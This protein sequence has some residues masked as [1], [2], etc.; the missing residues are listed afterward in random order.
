MKRRVMKKMVWVWLSLLAA[1]MGA[2]AAR[3]QAIEH[4]T[5]ANGARVW[6][7][8]SR[9][10]PMVDLNIAF[11]AGSRRD[12]SNQAG[13]AAVT[14]NLMS[15]GV[16]AHL[17]RPALDENQLA[18][19]WADLGA[20]FNDSLLPD[21]ISFNL[22]TLSYPDILPQAVA[23]AAQQLAAP[24]F[25]APLWQRERE[26]LVAA[27]KESRN[28]PGVVAS[29]NFARAVYRDHP[30]GREWDE[31]SLG[32]IQVGDLRAWHGR[33]LHACRAKVT[34][35]G[36]LNRAQADA[37]V[38][39]LLQGLPTGGACAPLP[40][41]PEVAPL[42]SANEQKQ[43][44]DSAQAHVY[45]GQPGF[46]REDPDFFALLVGNHIL[47]GGG[48]T[49]RLSREVREQ[50]GLSY[51]V[52]SYFQPGLHAGAFVVNLQTRPD[53][54]AQALQVARDVVRGFVAAGPSEA[55]LQ[56]AR[57]N[58]INGFAL[59]TDSNRKLLDNLALLAAYDLPLDY[60]QQWTGRVAAV[61]AQQV[62]AAFARVVQPERLVSVVVGGQP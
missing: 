47:G 7:I 31:Q 18:E 22:R 50:R 34:L 59:R 45:L 16:A 37:L 17:G 4:W 44:F 27:L 58:L 23:L 30:Y 6:L 1:L 15:K 28:R 9:N 54:A 52:Y 39:Q 57:D 11:D 43:S 24:A 25:A 48:F 36:A 5:L 20:M 51:S 61:T 60:W 10:L 14:L 56:A 13:L 32:A 26:R 49:S 55:E 2:G 33:Y 21:R 42:T 3:A 35:V 53:Q 12:P 29:R 41:V 38:Q 62:K 8:E 46:R 19:A 40:T